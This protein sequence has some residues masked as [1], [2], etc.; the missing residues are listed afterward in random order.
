MFSGQSALSKHILSTCILNGNSIYGYGTIMVPPPTHTHRHTPVPK[1]MTVFRNENSFQLA[2]A[3]KN[4][5]LGTNN[6]RRKNPK[7]FN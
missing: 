2:K 4:P 6:L 1:L 7:M 3:K 5:Y